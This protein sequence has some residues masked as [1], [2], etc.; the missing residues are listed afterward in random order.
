MVDFTSA[1]CEIL[2]ERIKMRRE[3]LE[4]SQLELSSLVGLGR[5]SISNIEKGKQS[6]PLSVIYEICDALNIDIQLL[7]PTSSEVK[8]RVGDSSKDSFDKYL[9]SSN[10]DKQTLNSIR[11]ILKNVSLYDKT[12]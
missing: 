4:L 10:L 3:E 12:L 8:E 2:G 6:P 5:T 11:Q 9:K 1:L 7:L